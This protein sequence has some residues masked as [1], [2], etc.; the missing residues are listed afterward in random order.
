MDLS[1]PAYENSEHHAEGSWPA[2]WSTVLDTKAVYRKLYTL[3][4][5][6]VHSPGYKSCL[7]KTVH[8]GQQAGPQ[9]WIQNLFTENCSHSPVH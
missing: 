5:R 4:S 3:A 8:S 7:Q 6:L 9:S 1:L 2:G